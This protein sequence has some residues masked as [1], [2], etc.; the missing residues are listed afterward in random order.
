MLTPSLLLLLLQVRESARPPAKY[1][2]QL[3]IFIHTE[4]FV[5]YISS[6]QR[7]ETCVPIIRSSL[8]S[9]KWTKA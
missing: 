5:R 2:S 8:T 9:S 6:G 1:Q 7:R 4:Q 3:E